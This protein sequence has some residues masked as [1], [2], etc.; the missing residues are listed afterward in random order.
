MNLV[1]IGSS[2]RCFY[3]QDKSRGH[4]RTSFCR[5]QLKIVVFFSSP[6][7][8]REFTSPF[9]CTIMKLG[10]LNNCEIF[11]YRLCSTALLPISH[12]RNCRFLFH[13]SVYLLP[14]SFDFG[15]KQLEKKGVNLNDSATPNLVGR[16]S[17]Y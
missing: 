11:W 17:T 2:L 14:N 7:F 1:T 8:Y 4:S 10:G 12:V 5:V 6:L 16:L 13:C 15:I 3:L 9:F